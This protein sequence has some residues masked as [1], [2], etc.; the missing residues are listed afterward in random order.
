MKFKVLVV[1][2]ALAS[3]SLTAAEGVP[4][5]TYEAVPPAKYE[6][7]STATGPA[8]Y[9]QYH[10]P[11]AAA[12][13]AYPRAD[14]AGN[15]ASS[16]MFRSMR[17]SLA[18]ISGRVG[19]GF[20][21][22]MGLNQEAF[23]SSDGGQRFRRRLKGMMGGIT[24]M[25]RGGSRQGRGEQ[26]PGIMHRLKH[27][28]MSI[29][30]GSIKPKRHIGP[31]PTTALGATEVFDA[32]EKVP[33]AL[34][35]G[36][37]PKGLELHAGHHQHQPEG[38]L[39]HQAA[40][41]QHI[42]STGP[43]QAYSGHD[44]HVPHYES[45]GATPGEEVTYLVPVWPKKES[46]EKL[47]RTITNRYKAAANT[48]L[49]LYGMGADLLK[50]SGKDAKKNNYPSPV[51]YVE[52]DD[53]VTS[54][55]AVAKDDIVTSYDPVVDHRTTYSSGQTDS[56]PSAPAAAPAATAA[57]PY[58]TTFE[59]H[60]YYT[61]FEPSPYRI[62]TED[63]TYAEWYYHQQQ[64]QEEELTGGNAASVTYQQNH[65][66]Q[67]NVL[68]HAKS[69]PLH[70]IKPEAPTKLSHATYTTPAAAAAPASP[71]TS[72]FYDSRIEQQQQQQQ[73][74]PQQQQEQQKQ[75]RLRPLTNSL[76]DTL[77][78]EPGLENQKMNQKLN[79]L[80]QKYTT[81][82]QRPTPWTPSTT[83]EDDEDAVDPEAITTSAPR[84]TVSVSKSVTT[85]VRRVTPSGDTVVQILD[86]KK[87]E[88]NAES[89]AAALQQQQRRMRQEI[90]SN[91][92]EGEFLVEGESRK[93]RQVRV[94]KKPK[95]K[96]E[97]RED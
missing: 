3:A 95:I 33:A 61:Y 80:R 91:T 74:H 83:L 85:S 48:V 67:E 52:E 84:V 12:A 44:V 39:Q 1:V 45:F 6:F 64:Q 25:F 75:Q 4:P 18:E 5:A 10:Y 9:Q 11:P 20:S 72:Y 38:D 76:S 47:L 29:L 17:D 63:E 49:G 50:D 2:V 15:L 14:P 68:T 81:P 94:V 60:P 28:M 31:Y 78:L 8:E 24:S 34:S 55:D 70:E 21:S 97:E 89:I 23:Q 69:S 51:P 82:P 92:L 53:I 30:P 54:Y 7:A 88:N 71:P 26:S 40:S 22:A 27:E 96:E 42:H 62:P 46:V 58:Y 41:Q 65:I 66:P 37:T 35:E 77:V 93:G 73:Q 86:H 32:V 36:R 19:R 90:S 59:S 43:S 56:Y 87:Q 16:S 79:K 13:Q 57:H